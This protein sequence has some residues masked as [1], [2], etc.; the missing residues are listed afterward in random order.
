MDVL[1]CPQEA[2]LK[3][4]EMW[5]VKDSVL[6]QQHPAM[7]WCFSMP[8]TLLILH[9]VILPLSADEGLAEGPSLPGRKGSSS[10]FKDCI[11][12]GSMLWFPETF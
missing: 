11:A 6:M 7:L 1:S 10:N 8:R 2:N 3:H 9:C 12:G 4:P 5:V